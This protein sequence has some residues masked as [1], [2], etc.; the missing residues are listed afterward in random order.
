MTMKQ[1]AVIMYA[2]RLLAVFK[3]DYHNSWLETGSIRFAFSP[4]LPHPYRTECDVKSETIHTFSLYV[5]QPGVLKLSCVGDLM[6]EAVYTLRKQLP[7]HMY[8]QNMNLAEAA[9]V[10]MEKD[11][12]AS[13]ETLDYLRYLTYRG[14]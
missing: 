14:Q 10:I 3:E 13:R 6:D 7:V 9:S 12:T 1:G 11:P 4:K 2:G 5:T 8:G